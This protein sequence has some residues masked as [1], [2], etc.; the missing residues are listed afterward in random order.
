MRFTKKLAG[1][2]AS[3]LF[4]VGCGSFGSTESSLSDRDAAQEGDCTLTQGYWKNHEEAWPVSSLTLGSTTYSKD[5]LLEI[6]RTPVKGNGLISLAHQLIA[7]KL[8]V[9][10]GADESDIEDVIDDADDL[11]GGLVVGV[12]TL[13]PSATAGLA[14]KLDAFNNGE[15]GPGHCDDAPSCDGSGCDEPSCGDGQVDAGEECD[16]G[17][18]LDGD[19]CTATCVC[20]PEPA[21]GDGHVDTGEVCDD[22]NTTAGDGCSATC[23][24]EGPVCGNGIVEDTEECDDGNTDDSDGCASC[25]CTCPH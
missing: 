23:Q 2:L 14:G 13:A 6:L 11:I 3:L 7:A 20:E 4:V 17:N 19:G 5:E 25:V 10:A 9:A 8:N 18:T 1:T 12:D 21:C 15:T 22:G 16:D 24:D